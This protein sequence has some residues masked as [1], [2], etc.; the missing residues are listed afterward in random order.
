MET[1]GGGM[2]CGREGEGGGRRE[3]R[4]RGSVGGE[5]EEERDREEWAAV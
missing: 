5:R 2:R 4:E 1:W 3:G